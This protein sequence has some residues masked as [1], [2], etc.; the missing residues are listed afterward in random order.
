[1]KHMCGLID[2]AAAAVLFLAAPALASLSA[3]V[4]APSPAYVLPQI[5]GPTSEEQPPRA[6]G[7]GGGAAP[8]R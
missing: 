8:C 2:L 5:G 4:P 7:A 3:P 6:P 1:M